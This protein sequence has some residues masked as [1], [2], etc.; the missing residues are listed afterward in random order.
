MG[1]EYYP[2]PAVSSN[3]PQSITAVCATDPRRHRN[4]PRIQP[5]SSSPCRNTCYVRSRSKQSTF[6]LPQN[7]VFSPKTRFFA[8]HEA[9]NVQKKQNSYKKE[10]KRAE[11][12]P[13]KAELVPPAAGKIRPNWRKQSRANVRFHRT[14]DN[15]VWASKARFVS[16]VPGRKCPK[17]SAR[18]LHF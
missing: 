5:F 9:E 1:A 10:Q 17:M 7:P 18:L 8:K 15:L 6:H 2:T 3:S 4:V 11:L 14:S 13:K 16:P 12:V